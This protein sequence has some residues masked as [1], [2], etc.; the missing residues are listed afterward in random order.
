[1]LQC[2]ILPALLLLPRILG[3]PMSLKVF[4]VVQECQELDGF[5]SP[6]IKE[7]MSLITLSE[8]FP[9]FLYSS[10]LDFPSPGMK[11]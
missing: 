3:D 9:G 10:G 7:A 1:M 8:I 4:I 5:D 6:L 2:G 11:R